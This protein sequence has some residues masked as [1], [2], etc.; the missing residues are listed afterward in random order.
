[1]SRAWVVVRFVCV[2][3]GLGECLLFYA[4]MRITRWENPP[5]SLASIVG[6][7][8]PLV[9]SLVGVVGSLLGKKWG[10]ILVVALPLFLA[11]GGLVF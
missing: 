4:A 5:Q 8:Y 1:M 11:I 10:Y 9:I 2:A 6:L 7:S 3:I